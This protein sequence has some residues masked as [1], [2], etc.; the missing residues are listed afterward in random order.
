MSTPIDSKVRGFKSKAHHLAENLKAQRLFRSQLR[1]ADAHEKA[2]LQSL[3]NALES[4]AQTLR[5]T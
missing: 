2:R 4:E 5:S 1:K 3:I